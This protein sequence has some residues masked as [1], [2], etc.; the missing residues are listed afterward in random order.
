M[1]VE[2]KFQAEQAIVSDTVDAGC[3]FAIANMLKK[4]DNII[5]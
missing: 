4:G 5:F 2:S 1:I 3:D